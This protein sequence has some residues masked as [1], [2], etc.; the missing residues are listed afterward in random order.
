VAICD[1]AWLGVISKKQATR[2][3]EKE[4]KK[5]KEENIFFIK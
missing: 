1:V 2:K 3:K 5:V 4:K